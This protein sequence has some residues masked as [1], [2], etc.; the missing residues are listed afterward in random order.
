[1]APAQIATSS[2]SFFIAL[3][4][5]QGSQALD[6]IHGYSGLYRFGVELTAL[7]FGLVT[8]TCDRLLPSQ[9][10]LLELTFGN[11]RLA[12]CC[13]REHDVSIV[14]FYANG[15]VARF[16]DVDPAAHHFANFRRFTFHLN[17]L[18]DVAFGRS[19]EFGER[20]RLRLGERFSEP[21]LGRQQPGAGEEKKHPHTG[22]IIAFEVLY[23]RQREVK[24][25]ALPRR[26]LDPNR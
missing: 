13:A 1:M 3:I 8:C 21:R 14:D 4:E 17:D 25:R 5:Y 23:R 2:R 10:Q 7:L 24:R 15:L 9:V 26:R 16:N 6:L 19:I 20:Q 18:A 12:D 22:S 11:H